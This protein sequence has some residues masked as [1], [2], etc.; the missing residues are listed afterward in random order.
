MIGSAVIGAGTSMISGNKQASAA[1]SAADAQTRAAAQADAT[2]REF[3]NTTKEALNPY[4]Q[5]G[6]GAYNTLND[7]L[8]VGGAGK[9]QATLENLPGYQFTLNQGLKSIQNSAAAKGLG[10]SG[11][12]LKGAATYATGLANQGWGSYADRLQNS[13]NTGAGAAS[14][15][16]GYSTAAGTQIGQNQIGAGN[17]QAAGQI[18]AA[19]A[20]AQGLGGVS[21][22]LNSL[23]GFY[24]LNNLLGNNSGANN[25]A[26]VSGWYNSGL[27][28]G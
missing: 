5:G 6:Y 17:A 13:A 26:P 10:T 25:N 21:N 16:G 1:R 23:S 20:Q 11:S 14:A 7:L 3:F 12:A 19:N 18:G 22:S 24:T 9:M 15:L 28:N 2:Q 8:G 4:I 27:I